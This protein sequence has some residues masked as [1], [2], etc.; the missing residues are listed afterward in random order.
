[1]KKLQLKALSL[2]AT[3]ILGREQLKSILGGC[4]TDSDCSSGGHCQD[5]VC[6]NEGGSASDTG[7]DTGCTSPP[8]AGDVRISAR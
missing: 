2:G 6:D 8:C 7:S 3:E 4:S 5:G 1:M